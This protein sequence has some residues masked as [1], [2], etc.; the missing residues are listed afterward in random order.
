[1]DEVV[2]ILGSKIFG[3]KIGVEDRQTKGIKRGR[4]YVKQQHN[5]YEYVLYDKY[6]GDFV[7][8]MDWSSSS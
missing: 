2:A 3:A 5:I 1:M 8:K 4:K 7:I 6:K